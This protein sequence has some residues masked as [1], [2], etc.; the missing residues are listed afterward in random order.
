MNKD[1][2]ED[3]SLFIKSNQTKIDTLKVYLDD[4]AKEMGNVWFENWG[5]VQELRNATKIIK[6]ER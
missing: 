6:N 5:K 3:I 4:K 1:L 2:K